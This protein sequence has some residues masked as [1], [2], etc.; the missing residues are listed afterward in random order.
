MEFLSRST[1]KNRTIRLI[2]DILYQKYVGGDIERK[3]LEFSSRN[4]ISLL[5]VFQ[6]IRMKGLQLILTESRPM[7]STGG[8]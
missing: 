8:G 7:D 1:E 5:L 6:H 4:D 2:G 3:N